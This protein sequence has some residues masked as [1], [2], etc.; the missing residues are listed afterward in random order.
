MTGPQ[1]LNGSEPVGAGTGVVKLVDGTTFCL[2]QRGGDIEPGGSDGLFFR[3]AR[4]VS[5]WRLLVDGRSAQTLSVLGTEAYGARFVLRRPPLPGRADSSLLVVRDRVVGDGLRETI[6]LENADRESTALSVTLDVDADFADLFAVKDGRAAAAPGSATAVPGADLHLHCSENRS[7]GL[8]VTA[9]ADPE[10]SAKGLSWRVVIPAH[11]RWSTEVTV[12]PLVGH[13]RVEPRFRDHAAVS[14]ADVP[15]DV[16]SAPKAWRE[17]VTLVTVDDVVTARVLDRAEQDL[18][19]LRI[20][21]PDGS[22]NTFVA[23]GAP[24][25]MT[26]F[27]RDSLLTSW[28]T[29]PLDARLALGTLRT[30][31]H[32]QGRR[33]DPVTEEEPGRILHE[34]R[35]GPERTHALGGQHYYGSADATPLFVMLLGECWRWGIDETAVRALLPAADAAVRWMR[36]YGD[37]DGDGF[38]EYRRATDKG[39]VNQGWRDSWDGINDEEGH[40]GEAPLALCEVQGYAYA[41]YLA[42]AELAEAF[43]DAETAA[44]H[45]KWAREL[46]DAFADRFWLPQGWFALALDRRKRPVDALTSNVG[47]CLWTG[48]VSDEHAAALVRRLRQPDMDSG[49][50]LRTLAATMGAYNP[51]SYHNGSVWPHDTALAVAGL[52]RYPHVPGA[53]DLALRLA[54]GLIDAA[55]ALGY[56]LPELFCGFPRDDFAPPVPYP[57]S[58]SPQAWASAAPLLLVRAFLGLDPDVPRRHLRLRPQLPTWWRTLRLDR[59]RLGPA[60]VGVIAGPDGA[61]VTGLPE[62]WVSS[63]L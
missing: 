60:M 52:M 37:R 7:R 24:W 36:E 13:E 63:V 27:G 38:I 8:R 53:V 59:L 51:M 34:L 42:R 20:S 22:G 9:T 21:D 6:T 33:I 58:C 57:T 44:T 10:V 28:M 55:A 39:L 26:L 18:D 30:L 61:A 29:L 3:D 32:R 2:S 48:I 46:R 54:A 16:G 19:A 43:G 12:Q 4:I 14:G 15:V 1:P 41:A 25:F 49:Y 17:R 31:A 50:G 45:R 56:R 35:R 40:L 62:G 11:G 5:T 23:A 47:H